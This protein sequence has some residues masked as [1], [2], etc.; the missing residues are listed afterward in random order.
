LVE[1]QGEDATEIV[2]FGK[3]LVFGEISYNMVAILVFDAKH[4][5]EKI[6]NVVE[7][8]FVVE[9]EFGKVAKILAVGGVLIAVHLKHG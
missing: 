5:K 3:V 6:N 7:E 2:A 9:E 1:R 4:V 8:V